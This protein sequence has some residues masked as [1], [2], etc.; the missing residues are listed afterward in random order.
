MTEEL[1]YENSIEPEIER[2][3][4]PR[5]RWKEVLGASVYNF[6]L[7]QEDKG[8]LALY[9]KIVLEYDIKITQQIEKQNQELLGKKLRADVNPNFKFTKDEVLRR[10]KIQVGLSYTND[11]ISKNKKK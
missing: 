7:Q 11:K 9:Q 3:T 4:Y 1:N 6:F 2:N 10:L 5:F 8:T